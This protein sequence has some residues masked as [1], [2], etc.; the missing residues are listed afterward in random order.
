MY[1]WPFFYNGEILVSILKNAG[2]E[3]FLR[4]FKELTEYPEKVLIANDI[5]AAVAKLMNIV[6]E[7]YQESVEGIFKNLIRRNPKYYEQKELWKKK[8]K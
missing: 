4:W 3:K 2:E 7:R 1:W 6:D 5:D 8:L